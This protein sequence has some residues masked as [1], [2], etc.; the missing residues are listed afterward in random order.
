MKVNNCEINVV[1]THNV[2][3]IMAHLY[4]LHWLYISLYLEAICLVMVFS[5]EA[6]SLRSH[7]DS[8]NYWELNKELLHQADS[9]T[10]IGGVNAFEVR[11][12]F[13]LS[14]RGGVIVKRDLNKFTESNSGNNGRDGS[15]H[16]DE[17]G[18]G[19][20]LDSAEEETFN[21]NFKARLEENQTKTLYNPKE[22]QQNKRNKNYEFKTNNRQQK[23]IDN[24]N[25]FLS[26]NSYLDTKIHRNIV[27]FVDKINELA[28]GDE[29]NIKDSTHTNIESHSDTRSSSSVSSSNSNSDNSRYNTKNLTGFVLNTSLE[30]KKKAISGSPSALSY[31]DTAHSNSSNSH[32]KKQNVPVT[33][34]TAET[35]ANDS[36]QIMSD[37]PQEVNANRD[38][39]ILYTNTTGAE[40]DM[41]EL[42]TKNTNDLLL[43]AEVWNVTDYYNDTDPSAADGRVM[44]VQSGFTMDVAAITGICLAV[45]VLICLVGAGSF[46]FYRRQYWNK[47][48]TLS[49]KCSNADSSGYIDD[50]TLR[51]N[52]E[53]MYSLDNDS[54]LN[55][56]EAMTIQNYWTDNVKHT[57]LTNCTHCH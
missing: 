51:E 28:A 18:A 19:D 1:T 52:S 48:Q 17:R 25:D 12:K 39:R 41:V 16:S 14:R 33:T 6:H 29:I 44:P 15:I 45:V 3:D 4:W 30:G 42:I 54:F 21:R 32:S 8:N 56:L 26:N 40:D 46:V 20:T 31:I 7:L 37:Q 38:D 13:I 36:S 24:Y 53:E 27:G 34:V 57:K 43:S 23:F 22:E 11:N 10:K 2:E 47:P 5:S 35:S 9:N 55:S 49:D 50:S